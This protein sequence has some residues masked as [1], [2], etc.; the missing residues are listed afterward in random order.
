MHEQPGGA[1]LLAAARDAIQNEILPLLP[2]ESRV[3][4]LMV[5]RAIAIVEREL[6]AGTNL[7]ATLHA[8]LCAVAGATDPLRRLSLDIR[9]GRYDPGMEGAAT[10]GA[11]LTDLA[12]ARC[13]ISNPK[14]LREH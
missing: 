14:A 12:R 13:A 2:A 8:R 5:L 10:V 7:S 11:L 6:Q 4:G 9:N 1:E 3:Q